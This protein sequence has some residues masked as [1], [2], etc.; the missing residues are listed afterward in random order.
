MCKLTTVGLLAVGI[1]G[2]SLL[3]SGEDLLERV[4]EGCRQVMPSVVQWRRDIHAHP[5]RSNREE[6]TARVVAE[7][8]REFGVDDVKTEVAKHGVVGLIRGKRPGPTVAL[9]ADMDALPVEEKTGLP[10]ASQNAGVMHA[11]GH[12]M[13]TAM[14]LGAAKVL[15][16]LRDVMPG[17]VKLIFQ[18]S[19]EGAPEGEQGG[20][21]LMVE[22]GVLEN[23]NVSAIFGMHVEPELDA[24]K[25]GYVLGS[26]MASSDRFGI[27]VIGKQTHGAKPWTGIDPIVPSAQIILALQTI[28]SQKIDARESVVV[29]VTMIHA[30]Q[31]FN[32]TPETVAM[33]GTIRTHN[34]EVRREVK[35]QIRWIAEQTAAAHGATA[36]IT[37][38]D[39]TSCVWNDPKLGKQMIPTL[40]RAM[41]EGNVL[42]MK[43]SMGA[44]D[45]SVYAERV[46][47]FFLRLGTRNASIGAIEQLHSPR[48]LF[49]E[50]AMPLG[51][52]TWVL[53]AI[54][55]LN[56]AGKAAASTPRSS[57][58][59][60]A[61]PSSRAPS[62][63]GNPGK[64]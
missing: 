62:R 29:S 47:G 6:R 2:S 5:E 38:E 11:C 35:K 55:Y 40:E 25:I 42:E 41:G 1:V 19:E 7:L 18:P 22:E 61:G 57:K 37:L 52:R 30:G 64:E 9:R 24:G 31:A 59:D 3:A 14:L 43:P 48:A 17:T 45:F 26:A 12:D 28:A 20:A 39:G 36:A 21:G 51:V 58:P 54:D 63:R 8:L 46:P 23:P 27:T 10:F 33:V 16:Q 15:I 32:I 53:L 49:D 56:A 34:P 44:E 50:A 13:H 60:V 4:D